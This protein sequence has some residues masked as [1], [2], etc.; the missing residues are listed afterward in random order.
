MVLAL[1]RDTQLFSCAY[2]N[3]KKW[4]IFLRWQYTRFCCLLSPDKCMLNLGS[5]LKPLQLT[6]QLKKT[7]NICIF[8]ISVW[9]AAFQYIRSSCWCTGISAHRSLIQGQKND[10]TCSVLETNLI[11]KW[12]GLYYFCMASYC[13]VLYWDIVYIVYIVYEKYAKL[14]CTIRVLKTV[15][16]HFTPS[17]NT[18]ILRREMLAS[19][20]IC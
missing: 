4:Y 12:C 11:V 13:N 15:Q 18:I 6:S 14:Q 1:I 9:H 2:H 10:T 3:H 17:R 5:S 19:V 8:C 20:I 7:N 16:K